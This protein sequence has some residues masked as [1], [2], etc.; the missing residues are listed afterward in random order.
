[1]SVIKYL[2]VA[3]R[4]ACEIENDSGLEA[5]SVRSCDR[6]PFHESSQSE[7]RGQAYHH[8]RS[9]YLE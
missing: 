1:M 5:V 8:C 3:L 2:D 6:H 9:P 4:V 7:E